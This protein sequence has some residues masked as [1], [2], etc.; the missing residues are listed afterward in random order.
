ML[1]LEII[2]DYIYQGV[3]SKENIIRLWYFLQ[4]FQ[5]LEIKLSLLLISDKL[6]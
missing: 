4:F 3:D 2:N 1:E 6:F 5:N